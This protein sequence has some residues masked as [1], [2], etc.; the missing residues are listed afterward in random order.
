MYSEFASKQSSNSG[1]A[2][3]R[4]AARRVA[5]LVAVVMLAACSGGE[6][7]VDTTSPSGSAPSTTIEMTSTAP[8]GSSSTTTAGATI[9]LATGDL[10]SHLVDGEG[11][12]LYL[13][14]NDERGSSTCDGACAV[15]WPPVTGDFTAGAGVEPTLLGS[16]TRSDGSDQV[17]YAGW[18][19][20]YY[21]GDRAPGDSNGQGLE[22]A[23]FA[24]DVEG[25][26]IGQAG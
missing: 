13:F 1:R 18:P 16:E 23:W 9:E 24:V 17:T 11:N 14:L 4:R 8:T 5:G 15:A 3:N 26:P 6:A 2:R 22:S 21:S 25:R 10:G 20:Y 19:L 7:P 12:T